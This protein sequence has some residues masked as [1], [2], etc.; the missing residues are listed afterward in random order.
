MPGTFTRAAITAN[1]DY[2]IA[3]STDARGIDWFSGTVS[4]KQS[5]TGT[6]KLQYS[7]D[8]GTTKLDLLNSS[9]VA[10]SGTASGGANFELGR[11]DVGQP[12]QLYLNVSGASGLNLVPVVHA[13]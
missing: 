8:G 1:G 9:G 11:G 10:V 2:L 3:N 12:I 4:I 6:W 5:G 7:P 13:N